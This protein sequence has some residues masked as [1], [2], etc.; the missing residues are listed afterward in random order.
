MRR[1]RVDQHY[2]AEDLQAS[3]AFIR[4]IDGLFVSPRAFP[5]GDPLEAITAAERASWWLA[6]LAVLADWLGSNSE[7]FPYC[8]ESMPLHAYWARAQAAA[9]TAVA[10]FGG[11]PVPPAQETPFSG[12]FPGWAPTPLQA[13]VERTR[14]AL[15]P[16]LLVIEDLTGAGKTEAALLAAHRWMAAGIAHGLFW[17]LPTMATANALYGRIRHC[18]TQ[19]FAETPSLILTHGNRALVELQ[20]AS[21]EPESATARASAWLAD[22]N[23]RALLSPVGVGTVDQALLAALHAR[24]GAL[25]LLGLLG[26]VLVVDEVHAYDAYMTRVLATLLELHARAG[27]SVVLMSATMPTAQRKELVGA[28]RRGRGAAPLSLT[29]NSYPLATR[30]GTSGVEEMPLATRPELVRTVKVVCEPERDAVM[31]HLLATAREGGCACWV[32]NTV[33]DALEAYDALKPVLGARVQLF[34]ARFTLGDRL[35][36]EQDVLLRFGKESTQGL[37]RGQ[38]LVATQV[39]EQSLDLDFDLMATDLAPIDLV[40]QRAGRL[41]RHR[42]G[43]RGVPTLVLHGPLPRSDADTHWLDGNSGTSRVYPDWGRLWLTSSLLSSGELRMP[44]DARRLMESVYGAQVL[45]AVPPALAAVSRR[46][47]GEAKTSAALGALNALPLSGSYR[48]GETDYWRDEMTPTRL[49][50]PTRVLVLARWDGTTLAP[51]TDHPRH[52]W[53]N[54]AVSVRAHVVAEVPLADL[55]LRAAAARVPVPAW[56]TLLPLQRQADQWQGTVLTGGGK[57][58]RPLVISYDSERGLH[59]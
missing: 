37:R 54:S 13:Y 3:Q 5:S 2:T 35:A 52:P 9:E 11:L 7:W 1:V 17:A 6:G 28:W 26:K 4:A 33:R 56:Q 45:E 55:L 19:L 48:V 40:V 18:Y 47:E 14:V 15:E 34:H 24:H 25:R 59:W 29:A 22:S 8:T 10:R 41:H 21:G 44:A 57:R 49:G 32:R 50:E 23:R 39:V 31:G 38:V 30:V 43:D 12:L 36:V 42:R 51:M 58:Q 46:V 53:A 27:G 16:Q 20:D